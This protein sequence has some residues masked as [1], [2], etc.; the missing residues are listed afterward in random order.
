MVEVWSMGLSPPCR[1]VLLTAKAVGV[2]VNVNEVDLFKGETLGLIA[3][4]LRSISYS[5]FVHDVNVNHILFK[6]NKWHPSSLQ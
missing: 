6:V 3:Y 4:E 1:A 5:L 2:D